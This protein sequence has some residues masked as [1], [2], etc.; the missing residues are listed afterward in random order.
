MINFNV[1]KRLQK[2]FLASITVL[3]NKCLFVL[4]LYVKCTMLFKLQNIFASM[5]IQMFVAIDRSNYEIWRVDH[6]DLNF[7][8]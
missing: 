7:D 6:I 1:I 4:Y 3:L 8:I 2:H 5:Q